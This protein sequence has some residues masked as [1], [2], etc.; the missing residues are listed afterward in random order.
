MMHCDLHFMGAFTEPVMPS[1]EQSIDSDCGA[2][3]HGFGSGGTK[4]SGLRSLQPAPVLLQLVVDYSQVRNA[5]PNRTTPAPLHHIATRPRC[6]AL[7]QSVCPR[8]W[9]S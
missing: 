4:T 7:S 8:V 1:L 3:R 9:P 6:H 2:G 5:G